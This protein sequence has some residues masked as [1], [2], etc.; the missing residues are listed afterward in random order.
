MGGGAGDLIIVDKPLAD[1]SCYTSY[2]YKN[3]SFVVTLV[4]F[5]KFFRIEAMVSLDNMSLTQLYD[6][7][8]QESKQ[9]RTNFALVQTATNRVQDSSDRLE[10]ITTRIQ[11]LQANDYGGCYGKGTHGYQEIYDPIKGGSWVMSNAYGDGGKGG[12]KGKSS[13]GPYDYEVGCGRGCGGASTRMQM[14]ARADGRR[15]AP[16]VGNAANACFSGHQGDQS[17]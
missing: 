9:L 6:A 2:M 11:A 13:F 4:S 14:G 10:V 3:K 8:G 12:G 7:F 17:F 15:L 16:P 1:K 5:F